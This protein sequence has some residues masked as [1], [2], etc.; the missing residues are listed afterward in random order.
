MIHYELGGC[1]LYPVRSLLDLQMLKNKGYNCKV[2]SFCLTELLFRLT[3][4]GKSEK[5]FKA[6]ERRLHSIQ[7]LGINVVW[8][9]P[10]NEVGQ[11]EICE[12]PPIV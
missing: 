10:I 11:G 7:A 5:S 8:F 9:M 6:V 12:F 3:P 1:R 4:I 2:E